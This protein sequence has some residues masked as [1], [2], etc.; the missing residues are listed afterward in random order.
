MKSPVIAI[1]LSG[2]QQ[3]QVDRKLT[4][5]WTAVDHVLS[6]EYAVFLERVCM[7]DRKNLQG[8]LSDHHAVKLVL[9]KPLE[10][11]GSDLRQ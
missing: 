9:Q 3:T 4:P 7:F 11:I 8:A 2:K 6:R 10:E 5:K 1:N